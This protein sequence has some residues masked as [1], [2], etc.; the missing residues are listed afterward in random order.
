ML[1]H[2]LNHGLFLSLFKLIYPA[3][4]IEFYL[5]LKQFWHFPKRPALPR[6]IKVKVSFEL[7]GALYMYISAL[8]TKKFDQESSIY[9]LIHHRNNSETF[10][11]VHKV[12]FCFEEFKLG[13]SKFGQTRV[14]VSCTFSLLIFLA[15]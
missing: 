4:Y 15:I 5:N 6:H 14:G 1:N 10:C 12:A 7:F 11:N 8:S 2:G 9:S 3:Q 13:I